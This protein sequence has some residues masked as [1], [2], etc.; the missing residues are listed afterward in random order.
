MKI[1]NVRRIEKIDDASHV[2]SKGLKRLVGGQIG[3]FEIT[4][5]MKHDAYF[6][7]ERSFGPICSARELSEQCGEAAIRRL[8]RFIGKDMPIQINMRLVDGELDPIVN[9]NFYWSQSND[10]NQKYNAVFQRENWQ[11]KRFIEK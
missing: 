2:L 10:G 7:L 9:V 11:E 8:L 1:V 5:S 6:E 4:H 3:V